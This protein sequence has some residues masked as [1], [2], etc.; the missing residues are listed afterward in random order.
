M[1][2]WEAI[3]FGL[4]QGLAEFLPISSTAHIVIAG[5]LLDL[6]FP[7]LAFE[8]FLHQASVLA[9]IFYFRRDLWGLV[10]GSIRFLV[11]RAPADSVHLMFSIYILVAT[12][13]TGALGYLMQKTM[14]DA[15]KSPVLVATALVATGAFL[16]FIERIH[17]LGATD[18]SG[19]RFHHSIL[20]GLGQTLA[21]LPGVSRSGATLIAALWTGLKRETA[22]RY[23]FLLAIPV[24]LGSSVLAVPHF[25]EGFVATVGLAPL[26]VAFAVTF[27]SSLAGIV[28]LIEFLK[29]TKLIYFALYCFLLGAFVFFYFDHDMHFDVEPAPVKVLDQDEEG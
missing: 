22:V 21:V 10:T 4:V 23:S 2:F 28:W 26:L 1:S 13:I 15:L 5:Y 24:I 3:L 7:G 17:K 25:R 8:I 14:G 6:Q 27:F 19:M 12:I 11:S 29:R 16:I 20:V 9:V 18:E